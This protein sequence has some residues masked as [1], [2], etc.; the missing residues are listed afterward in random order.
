MP[1]NPS[2]NYQQVLSMALEDRGPGRQDLVSNQIALLA[3]LQRKGMWKPYSGPRI[4]QT[5]QI[6]K[7]TGQWYSGYDFLDNPPTELFNDAY[8][9]PKMVAVP[10]SLTMEEILNNSGEAEIEDVLTSYMDAAEQAL[11][12]TIETGLYSDGTANNGK[13]LTGLAAA[14]PI[15]TNSGTYG[16][17]D[18]GA[19][20]LWRTSTFDAN[21]AFP[22]IGTQVTPT[23]IRPMLT[24]IFLQRSRGQQSADLLLMSNEHYAAYDAALVAQQRIVKEGSLGKLGFQS[25]EYVGAGRSVEVVMAGGFNS[26]MPANTTFGLNT[27][28]LRM[29]YNPNRNMDKLFKGDGQMPINQDAIAQFLGFMGELTM[30]NPLFNWR[31]YDSNPAA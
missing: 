22:T 24:Q 29:R 17:I 25:I 30:T 2:I 19:Y 11:K 16:G 3:V 9:T 5:L 12:E 10:I 27:D 31:F 23:T 28:T 13:Q 15:I 7:P 1:I 4:R 18:R 20:A 6:A 26:A 8:Y 14:V 21:S